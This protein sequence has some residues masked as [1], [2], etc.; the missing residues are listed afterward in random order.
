MRF[1][2]H[3]PKYSPNL[4]G[5]NRTSKLDKLGW[6]TT[7]SMPNSGWFT[8]G[9]RSTLTRKRGA[10]TESKRTNHRRGR[11]ENRLKRRWFLNKEIEFALNFWLESKDE[12]KQKWKRGHR[13]GDKKSNGKRNGDSISAEE[14]C[15]TPKAESDRITLLPR[16]PQRD[17]T[18]ARKTRLESWYRAS[19]AQWTNG[20][21]E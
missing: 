12:P 10:Q 15:W 20:K 8:F 14:S 21:V 1:Q 4:R 13:E 7:T 2:S 17:E 6:T 16:K 18:P 19:G 3:S 5:T 9:I 11:I